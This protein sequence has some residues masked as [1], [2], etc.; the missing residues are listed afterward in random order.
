MRAVPTFLYL[1]IG[2]GDATYWPPGRFL[3]AELS[4]FPASARVCLTSAAGL[5]KLGAAPMSGSGAGHRNSGNSVVSGSGPPQYAEAKEA[6]HNERYRE[7]VNFRQGSQA[8]KVFWKKFLALQ[9]CASSTPAQ[10]HIL[11]DRTLFS[12]ASY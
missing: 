11:A 12:K 5:L 9:K 1:Y 10:A 6:N 7:H 3:C 8:I 2:I 4:S